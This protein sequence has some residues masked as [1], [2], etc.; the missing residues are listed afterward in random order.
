MVSIFEQS[1]ESRIK[2]DMTMKRSEFHNQS[3]QSESCSSGYPSTMCT[4]H[5]KPRG[6]LNDDMEK[7][8]VIL[9]S[10]GESVESITKVVGR[11]RH[12]I[13]HILQARGFLTNSQ[14]G[15]RCK[16]PEDKLPASEE[17]KEQ[18]TDEER[19]P[20]QPVLKKLETETVGTVRAGKP[21]RPGESPRKSKA[22]AI[23]KPAPTPHAGEKPQHTDRWSPPVVNALCKVI[24][25]HNLYP[26]MSREDVHKMV[27]NWNRHT[28]PVFSN[29]PK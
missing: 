20:G 24:M 6:S 4:E 21:E 25:Q 2:R 22:M 7:R 29:R 26:G 8:I 1:L 14:P 18:P 5:S 23:E 15:P 16:E 13:V 11:A 3:P 9:Y 10:N 28:R 27:S 12:R 19:K 17:L